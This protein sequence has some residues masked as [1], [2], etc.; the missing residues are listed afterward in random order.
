MSGYLQRLVSNARAP[1]GGIRPMVGTPFVEAMPASAAEPIEF[2]GIEEVAIHRQPNPFAA[3]NPTPPQDIQAP[4]PADLRE[5][6]RARAQMPV[7]PLQREGKVEISRPIADK[8]FHE[9]EVRSK[10]TET[11]DSRAVPQVPGEPIWERSREE[12]IRMIEPRLTNQ[13]LTS[14]PSVYLSA[15]NEPGGHREVTRASNESDAPAELRNSVKGI[16]QPPTRDAFGLLALPPVELEIPRGQAEPRPQPTS[17]PLAG[18]QGELARQTSPAPLDQQEVRLAA[19]RPERTPGKPFGANP[20]HEFRRPE[21]ETDEI[22][23][24][25]GRIEVTAVPPAPARPMVQPRRKSLQL[26]EYLGRGRA[27]AP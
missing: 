22:Q 18:K 4:A 19:A 20:P 11:L 10:E 6:N 24:H 8:R 13:T 25:I 1:R 21:L 12:V 26:D 7:L 2:T 14:P 27:G 17:M 23:I 5:Q 9:T 3:A 15:P 16:H